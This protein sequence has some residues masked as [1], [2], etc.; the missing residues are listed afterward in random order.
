[1]PCAD[2]PSPTECLL[3]EFYLL[4]NANNMAQYDGMGGNHGDC[5][6][7]WQAGVYHSKVTWMRLQIDYTTLRVNATDHTFATREAGSRMLQYGEAKDCA[8]PHSKRGKAV[9]DLRGTPFAVDGVSNCSCSTN[10]LG[11]CVCGQWTSEGWKNAMQLQCTDN[12]QYCTVR[13][14]GNAGGCELTTGYLQLALF[15][16]GWFNRI[17]AGTSISDGF[18]CI[19]V[20]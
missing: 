4:P 9:I 14:G 16:E 10:G 13:C 1:M 15:D 5:A 3:N 8:G 19:A 18:T 12:N 2:L 6:T 17:C 7:D 11:S 20:L